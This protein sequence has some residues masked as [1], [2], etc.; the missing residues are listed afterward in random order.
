[1]VNRKLSLDQGSYAMDQGSYAMDQG[2]HAVDQG[3]YAMDQG[4]YTIDQ[5]CDA[6]AMDQVPCIGPLLMEPPLGIMNWGPLT[7]Q[8]S[9]CIDLFYTVIQ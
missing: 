3:S 9:I 1:M 2:S 7:S 6:Y 5:G 8:L 4:S